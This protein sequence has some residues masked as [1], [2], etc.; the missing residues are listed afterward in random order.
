MSTMPSPTDFANAEQLLFPNH[1]GQLAKAVQI[2]AHDWDGNLAQTYPAMCIVDIADKKLPGI[3][4]HALS[5]PDVSA[6]SESG[7]GD[8]AKSSSFA[9]L[10]LRLA[11][12]FGQIYRRKD[13][14]ELTDYFNKREAHAGSEVTQLSQIEQL[15]AKEEH[16]N[17]LHRPMD[18]FNAVVAKIFT[19]LEARNIPISPEQRILINRQIEKLKKKHIQYYINQANM[20]YPGAVEALEH[21]NKAGAVNAI[22]TTTEAA[23]EVLRIHDA[24]YKKNLFSRAVPFDIS[25]VAGVWAFAGKAGARDGAKESIVWDGSLQGFKGYLAYLRKQNVDLGKYDLNRLRAIYNKMHTFEK[26]KPNNVPLLEIRDRFMPEQEKK[27]NAELIRNG[28]VGPEFKAG[29]DN[30]YFIGESK[31]DEDS[32]REDVTDPA[33]PRICGFK[34]QWTGLQDRRTIRNDSRI[35]DAVHLQDAKGTI[36]LFGRQNMLRMFGSDDVLVRGYRTLLDQMKNG[37]LVAGYQAMP[38]VPVPTRREH[39]TRKVAA[40]RLAWRL[41]A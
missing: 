40:A 21:S 19:D 39:F 2:F 1:P 32:T 28:Y 5:V 35:R 27:L 10:R 41:A 8:D 6:A 33:S 16:K 22:Y 31:S 9:W 26:K 36:R 18:T 24:K 13:H 15:F 34:L 29:P 11:N 38:S 12:Y 4:S 3:F 30:M 14:P 37:E 25:L 17:A 23:L 20:L 7:K